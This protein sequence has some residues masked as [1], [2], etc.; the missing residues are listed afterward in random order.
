VGDAGFTR[1]VVHCTGVYISVEGND[2][3]LVTFANDEVK[4]VREG[5]LS[6]LLGELLKILSGK[7][8]SGAEE[9]CR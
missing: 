1:G 7:K 4:A 9:K 5:E 6:H 2:G 8:K 3:G